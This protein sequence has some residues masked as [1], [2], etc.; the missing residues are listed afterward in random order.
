MSSAHFRLRFVMA[1]LV[2]AVLLLPCTTSLAQVTD[3]SLTVDRDDVG[4]G[5]MVVPGRWTPMRIRIL[6]RSAE[7]RDVICQ[8]QV[9]DRDG[10][11]ALVQ[12]RVTL[13]P[14][15][16][17]QVWLYA[18]PSI[19]AFGSRSWEVRVLEAG[20]DPDDP[21]GAVLA[22]TQVIPQRMAKVGQSVIGVLSTQSL[23][24]S[25]YVKQ[26]TWHEK[27]HMLQ[28]FS[29]ADLPDRWYGMAACSKI[30]WT[31]EG[32]DPVDPSVA[33]SQLTALRQWIVRGGHL[34]ISLPSA[35]QTWTRSPLADLLGVTDQQMVPV[36]GMPPKLLGP[37]MR[38]NPIPIRMTV[39]SEPSAENA[40]VRVIGRDDE[41]RP[42]II[43]H[44]VGFGAVTVM[45][46]DLSDRSLARMGLPGGRQR[47]WN[48]IFHWQ[49]PAFSD[50]YIR[51]QSGQLALASSMRTVELDGFVQST[52][53]M[54]G[55]VGPM[56]LI[57]MVLLGAY[58]LAA[59]PM[60]FVVLKSRKI[61][62][63]SWLCF[64]GLAGVFVVVCWSAAYLAAPARTSV[65]HFSVLDIAQQSPNQP[66]VVRAR[67]IASAMSPDF[68]LVDFSLPSTMPG[69]AT[70][71]VSA[72]EADEQ[73]AFLD[74]REYEVPAADPSTLTLPSRATAKQLELDYLGPI[75]D[76]STA[77]KGVWGLPQVDVQLNDQYWPVGNIGHNLPGDLQNVI[78]VYCPGSEQVP[79]VWRMRTWPAA[80]LIE[81]TPPPSAD[82]LVIPPAVDSN[83]RRWVQEGFLGKL[84]KTKTGMHGAVAN[85]V[86][87]DDVAAMELL[88][89]YDAMPTPNFRDVSFAGRPHVYQRSWGAELDLTHL[90][91]GR[92]LIILGHLYESPLPMPLT[93]DGDTPPSN[94]HTFVRMIVELDQPS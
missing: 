80:K 68:G 6:D 88:S 9:G 12:R 62:R 77:A 42:L 27:I 51:T 46:I 61:E 94:G 57:A 78:I 15:Q 29:L 76:V 48:R 43:T 74:T 7:P 73:A 31:S 45:G 8:W 65:S 75:E 91:S 28:G 63:W 82:R 44:R 41:N 47:I 21:P 93:M 81:L 60:S 85:T 92:R 20:D 69:T 30:I 49:T 1:G 16:L 13:T 17:Q 24:L 32:G 10:D 58:W 84:F 86:T 38:R 90:I 18:M 87:S 34:V 79:W 22:R 35:G 23:G 33:D 72:I 40:N 2:V 70:V 5:G 50:A 25:P 39:F 66:L 56:L 52:V 19:G 4:F 26:V 64:A 55:A 54:R 59:G 36:S 89:F 3:V 53:A 83:Q 11:R 71:M 67:S 14:G 37:I